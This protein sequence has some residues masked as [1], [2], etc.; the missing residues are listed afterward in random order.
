MTTT[1]EV[2]QTLAEYERLAI[3]SGSAVKI[4]P[5]EFW[6][7]LSIH[8]WSPVWS[9]DEPPKYGRATVYRDEIPTS[10]YVSWDESIP[11]VDDWRELWLRKPMKLFGAYT[12]RTALRRAF[13]D[14]IG[15]RIEP[16]ETP[17]LP[18]S[19]ATV[20]ADRDW[21]AELAE[22]TTPEAVKQLHTDA[23]ASRA[24]TVELEREFRKRIQTLADPLLAA[25]APVLEAVA[26]MTPAKP[27]PAPPVAAMIAAPKPASRPPSVR[28][29][30]S[31]GS[32]V[33]NRITPGDLARTLATLPTQPAPRAKNGRR[34]QKPKPRGPRD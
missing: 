28:S 9:A 18:G 19:P 23:K 26:S 14:I 11:A 17:D 12:L 30:R 3:S 16:D 24:V 13:R 22:A 6:S 4:E 15:E 32:P 5:P 7:G 34:Q 27:K 8:D 20:S 10:V 29:T 1:D 21:I 25:I 31:F 33:V 2:Q